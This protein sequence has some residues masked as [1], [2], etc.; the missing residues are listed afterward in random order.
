MEVALNSSVLDR[1][2]LAVEQTTYTGD[3]GIT[4]ATRVADDLKLGRF[5]LVKLALSLEEVFG[6]ELPDEALKQFSTIANI[7]RYLK[8]HYR[9]EVEFSWCAA[10]TSTVPRCSPRSLDLR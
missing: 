4:S 9:H 8:R 1:V 6:I 5:G 10:A 7:V 3:D 2:V